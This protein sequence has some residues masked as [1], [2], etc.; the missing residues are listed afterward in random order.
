MFPK[1]EPDQTFQGWKTDGFVA[2]PVFKRSNKCRL[3]EGAHFTITFL[4]IT[5]ID[6]DETNKSFGEK[7][8][9]QRDKNQKLV[10]KNELKRKAISHFH[11]IIRRL[12][13]LFISYHATL[14][15]VLI[16]FMASLL[17]FQNN[18]SWATTERCW[19]LGRLVGVALALCFVFVC[20]LLLPRLTVLQQLFE[21]SFRKKWSHSMHFHSHRDSV[22]GG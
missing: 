3:L 20:C 4:K 9:S 22:G 11:S 21:R 15:K 6:M 7:K 5:D 13:S 16:T 17:Y 18:Y 19:R 8:S 14:L 10:K 12:T 2:L 1:H